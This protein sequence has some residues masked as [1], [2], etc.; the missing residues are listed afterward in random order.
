M[1]IRR[2]LARI[3]HFL[4]NEDGPTSV[5]YGVIVMLVFCAVIT[6]VQLLGGTT[7]GSLK[8][9]SDT[10]DKAIQEARSD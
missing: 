2:V 3:R 5:E 7:S 1:T 9:S 10:I 4:A 6:V 8:N